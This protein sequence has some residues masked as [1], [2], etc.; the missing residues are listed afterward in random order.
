MSAKYFIWGIVI[1]CLLGCS[2]EVSQVAIDDNKGRSIA[3]EAALARKGRMTASP[4]KIIGDF[5]NVQSNGEHQWGYSVELWRHNSKVYGLFSGS[6]D[7]MIVGDPPTGIL[8][9]QVFD[10]KTGKLSFRT[11]L[12][13]HSYIFDGILTKNILKGRLLNTETNETETIILRRSKEFDSE[14]MDE[15]ASYEDWKEY[16]DRILRFRGPK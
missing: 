13:S 14:T 1:T 8:A 3:N 10:K 16:A 15:F 7:S 4:V 9:D 12:P 2:R 11:I 6:S 5:T